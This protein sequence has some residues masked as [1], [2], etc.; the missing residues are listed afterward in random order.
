MGKK[1]KSLPIPTAVEVPL[2]TQSEPP[3]S[4]EFIEKLFQEPSELQ[5]PPKESPAEQIEKALQI[6]KDEEDRAARIRER[7]S[8]DAK[9]FRCVWC[10]STFLAKR[11]W[12]LYCSKPCKNAAF[13]NNKARK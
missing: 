1:K 13:W 10:D 2:F 7:L 11:A 8:G 3:N 4:K 5:A 12:A 9:E 6:L